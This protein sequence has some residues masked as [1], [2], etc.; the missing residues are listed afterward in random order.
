MGYYVT[1]SWEEGAGMMSFAPHLDSDK[2][3]L[4][5]DQTPGQFLRLNLGLENVEDGA[6]TALTWALLISILLLVIFIAVAY[7]VI[8]DGTNMTAF[9]F[10]I[11]GGVIASIL[12]F[13]LLLMTIE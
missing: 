13:F 10:S 5:Q 8:Y 6:G 7:N 1:H 4:E 11:V 3:K 2:P 9:I 12:I